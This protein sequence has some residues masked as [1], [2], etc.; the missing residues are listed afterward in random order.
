ML[1]IPIP[2][3][4]PIPILAISMIF[5]TIIIM[6]TT[7]QATCS[8]CCLSSQCSGAFNNG[9]GQCC[10]RDAAGSNYCC[11]TGM[12][13][14][15]Q[16]GGFACMNTINTCQLCCQQGICNQAY[17]GAPGQCCGKNAYGTALCCPPSSSSICVARNAYYG[18]DCQDTT[19]HGLSVTI[20][21]VI[22]IM[23]CVA[24]IC[25]ALGV[26]RYRQYYYP[27]AGA[28]PQYAVLEP[29]AAYQAQPVYAQPVYGQPV[30]GQPVYGQPVYSQPAYNPG[31]SGSTV[32][33]AGAAGFVGGMLFESMLS[34]NNHHHHHHHG[35]GWGNGDRFG[36]STGANINSVF[37]ADTS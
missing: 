24:C 5:I 20:V 36:A 9:T 22:V 12:A 10:G 30:Y 28:A 16:N 33:G 18:W 31:Y 6:P 13:C 21:T 37:A 34:N 19:D 1:P 23:S 14:V 17:Q 3:K 32:A 27:A 4:I 2:I 8:Q 25:C 35:G 7:V 11:G 29:G 26:K 15:Y